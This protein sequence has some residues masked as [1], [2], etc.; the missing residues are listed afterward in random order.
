M[1]VIIVDDEIRIGNLIKNLIGWDR[2]GLELI[3]VYQNGYDVLEQF[4]KEPADI[5][6]CDIEMPEITGLELIRRVSSAYP[7]TRCIIVSGFRD[8]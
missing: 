4:E 5:L 1:K 7:A 2:L 6:I 3:G 8:F